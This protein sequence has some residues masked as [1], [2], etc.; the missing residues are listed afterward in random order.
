MHSKCQTAGNEEEKMQHNVIFPIVSF[1]CIPTCLQSYTFHLKETVAGDGRVP[2]NH[3]R[4]G[5][6]NEELL[7][8]DGLTQNIHLHLHLF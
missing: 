4:A 6:S 2:N 8:K 7:G 3:P 5:V 1:W